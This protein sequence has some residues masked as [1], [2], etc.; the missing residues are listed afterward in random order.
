MTETE[1]KFWH[2]LKRLFGKRFI[3]T[4]QVALCSIV[5]KNYDYYAN[6]LY[7]IID[8]GIFTKRDY[9]LVALIELNDT[10]HMQV[11][12]RERDEKVKQIL[13]EAGLLDIFITFW[14]TKENSDEYVKKRIEEVIYE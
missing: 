2:K 3:I 8:F 10:S 13:E 5:Q 7:R 14:T 12:R 11:N 6:E 1:T 9:D 4:P